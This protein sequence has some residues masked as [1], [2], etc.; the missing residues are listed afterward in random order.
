M[1]IRVCPSCR[2]AFYSLPE[3]YISCPHCGHVLY[4]RR[5]DER[6]AASSTSVINIDSKSI[7]AEIRDYSSTGARIAYKGDP[8]PDD[9]VIE[10]DADELDIHRA[11]RP[12][13]TRTL[14]KSTR[15]SGVAFI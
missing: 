12:V 4:D 5:S 7:T 15:V 2:K 11:G 1:E 3:D 8:L 13:W 9:K 6:I 10:L 14:E